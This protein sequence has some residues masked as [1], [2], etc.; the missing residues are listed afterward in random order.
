MSFILVVNLT[1]TILSTTCFL[2]LLLTLESQKTSRPRAIFSLLLFD[3]FLWSL[4]S[5]MHMAN[6]PPAPLI[7][8]K[9]WALLTREVSPYLYYLF[10]LSFL[11]VKKQE[12]RDMLVLLM[13][14][15]S[16][17]L[18]CT[19]FYLWKDANSI[20]YIILAV[21]IPTILSIAVIII[22]ISATKKASKQKDLILVSFSMILLLAGC[23]TRDVLNLCLGIDLAVDK[24]IGIIG[25]ALIVVVLFKH[26]LLDSRT[27]ISKAA[28]S[29]VSIAATFI[30]LISIFRVIEGEGY[31]L[32]ISISS[33]LLYFIVLFSVSCLVSLIQPQRSRQIGLIKNNYANSV[34]DTLTKGGR[35]EDVL[36]TTVYNIA[37][38]TDLELFHRM[39]GDKHSFK[40]QSSQ[41]KLDDDELEYLKSLCECTPIGR[42]KLKSD[43]KQKASARGYESLLPLPNDGS[44]VGFILL[45]H[46]SRS[47]QNEISMLASS[48][49]LA[50]TNKEML[51][52]LHREAREDQLTG[53]PNRLAT[54]EKLDDI[55]LTGD[56]TFL[57][58]EINDFRFFSQIYGLD[59]EEKTII[60]LADILKDT[61]PDSSFISRFSHRTF[62][63]MLKGD[64]TQAEAVVDKMKTQ[65]KLSTRDTIC[66][67]LT[68]ST[69][70][71]R[72]EEKNVDILYKKALSALEYAK[73]R[74]LGYAAYSPQLKDAYKDIEMENTITAAYALTAAIDLKDNYTFRHSENVARLA[75]LLAIRIGLDKLEQELIYESGLVHDIGKIAISES[76]LSKPEKLTEKEYAEMKSHVYKARQIV[77]SMP[78]GH[79]LIDN[80]LSHHERWDGKGY[81][82]GLKEKE[83]P[84]GG[85]CLA[86]A[87]AYDAMTSCR[88]YS[89]AIS[90]QEAI[91]EIRS[92]KGKQFDPVL[93]EEFIRMIELDEKDSSIDSTLC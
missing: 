33:L 42:L 13:T 26:N 31:H 65:F 62:A 17:L 22:A 35:I 63:M 47:R 72:I 74:H 1:L 86:L 54:S 20:G 27:F 79:L 57:L 88:V 19:C 8:W 44:M 76:I 58:I 93:A 50:L 18:T 64:T 51:F 71:T 34:F 30:I 81:P 75:R 49:A 70:S 46:V 37:G 83:I 12:W 11:K 87:D 5:L 53:L 24:L 55:D 85:R 39:K 15:A 66:S 21:T 69:G 6:F 61:M 29:L 9:R 43:F 59:A 84:I 38:D 68:L 10:I 52:R 89:P 40:S 73:A 4:M 48:T 3:Y 32:V 82:Y 16:L 2:I 67:V 7:S 77:R 78:H 41:V 90:K 23:I 60:L 45:G 28:V 92:N 36:R 14:S 80:V 56:N 25:S 91:L